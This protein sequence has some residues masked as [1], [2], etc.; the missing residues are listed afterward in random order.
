MPS[1]VRLAFLMN[2]FPVEVVPVA[3]STF[4]LQLESGDFILLESGDFILLEAAP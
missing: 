3:P 1:L 2:R 4:R